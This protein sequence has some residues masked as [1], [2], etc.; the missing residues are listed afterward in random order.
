MSYFAPVH[1]RL[2]IATLER[3]KKKPKEGTKEVSDITVCSRKACQV[4]RKLNLGT[5]TIKIIKFYRIFILLC[6]R[7]KVSDRR[8]YTE[9]VTHFPGF[10][11]KVSVW[12]AAVFTAG[13]AG[14]VQRCVPSR[15][16]SAFCGTRWLCVTVCFH[17]PCVRQILCS[18]GRSSLCRSWGRATNK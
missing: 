12:V 3:K 18:Q 14:K 11:C 13:C 17:P 2:Q 9:G 15:C 16:D 4:S 10:I 5:E 1:W 8:R 7:P 6:F